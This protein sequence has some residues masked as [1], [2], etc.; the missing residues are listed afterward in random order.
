[1]SAELYQ[2]MNSVLKNVFFVTDRPEKKPV[3][4]A[5]TIT[6]LQSEI[7]PIGGLYTALHHAKYEYCFISA[8]DL[9]FLESELIDLLWSEVQSDSDIV[10]PVW[11]NKLEPLASFYHKRCLPAI[12]TSLTDERFLMKGF[13]DHLRVAYIDLGT[14]FPPEKLH[15][16]FFNINTPADFETAKKWQ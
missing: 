14:Y 2:R 9:P 15:R 13:W 11:E 8:C 16:M 3:Q 4:G 5:P 1:M 12:E 6:D 7:G 10:V